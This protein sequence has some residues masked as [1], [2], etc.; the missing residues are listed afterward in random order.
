VADE[1]GGR[2]RRWWRGTPPERFTS[3]WETP[4]DFVRYAE[5]RFDRL[6]REL[7]ALRREVRV[8]FVALV[9]AVI[10]TGIFT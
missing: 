4:E 3:T 8:G 9:A 1:N 6:E 7:H 5:F 10:G 2:W